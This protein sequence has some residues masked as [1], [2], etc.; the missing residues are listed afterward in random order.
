M[1]VLFCSPTLANA[2]PAAQPISVQTALLL[3]LGIA[4][5]FAFSSLARLHRR[6]DALHAARAPRQRPAESAPGADIPPE[7]VAVI[8][9]AVHESLGEDSHIVA[10]TLENQ[11]N[12]W[13]IE[14]RR[15]IFSSR[16]TR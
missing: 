10:I 4:L 16:K 14:G 7:I 5:V 15:Q 3:I 9:A 11:S 8:S 6:V 1:P 12:A 2:E 13:S